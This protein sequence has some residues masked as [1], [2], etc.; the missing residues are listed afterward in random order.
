VKCPQNAIGAVLSH[1]SSSKPLCY[2]FAGIG[3]KNITPV[4]VESVYTTHS[5]GFIAIATLL[6]MPMSRKRHKVDEASTAEAGFLD[7][8]SYITLTGKEY[9]FGDDW[10]RTRAYVFVRDGFRCTWVLPSGE[11]CPADFRTSKLDPDHILSRGKGGDD[12]ESNLRT[13]C[14]EH[15]RARHVH[16]M[17]TKKEKP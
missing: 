9:Y 3:L 7:N 5:K 13:L 12:R 4:S 17:W 14:R 2:V 10:K 1:R 11:R 6:G 16:P 8:R 15:H